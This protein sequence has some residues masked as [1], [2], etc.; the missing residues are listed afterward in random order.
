VFGGRGGSTEVR[1]QNLISSCSSIHK[2]LFSNMCSQ[3]SLHHTNL[4]WGK[5]ERQRSTT[6][7]LW[8]L[9]P[10]S[11]LH[12]FCSHFI[13]QNTVTWPHQIQG[14]VVYL[15]PRIQQKLKVSLN[16]AWRW[17]WILR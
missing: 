9:R 8:R 2:G 14:N 13:G 12:R 7:F 1:T 10:W 16:V 11:Y 4:S 6:S 3:M 15:A 17:K 5:M